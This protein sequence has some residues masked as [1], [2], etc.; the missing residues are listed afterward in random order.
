MSFC[1]FPQCSK[2]SFPHSLSGVKVGRGSSF[3]K[4]SPKCNT[5]CPNNFIDWR[6]QLTIMYAFELSHT[7]FCPAE[8]RNLGRKLSFNEP[9]GFNKHR[10]PTKHV[11]Y[12]AHRSRL[13]FAAKKKQLVWVTL[14]IKN[15]SLNLNKNLH[16]DVLSWRFTGLA[17]YFSHENA[18]FQSIFHT[19]TQNFFTSKST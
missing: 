2:F 15:I 12:F 8:K 11:G 10:R 7:S 14:L 16:Y 17:L 3:F 4:C 5:G 18:I 19:F 9:K 1:L 6:D 13:L